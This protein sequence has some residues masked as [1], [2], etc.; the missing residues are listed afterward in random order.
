[1]DYMILGQDVYF[2]GFPFGITDNVQ[3]LSHYYPLPLIKKGILSASFSMGKGS[4]HIMYFDAINNAVFQE[5]QLSFLI[6]LI[7]S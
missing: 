7:N 2:L 4:V 3:T 1:M 6:K 5:V